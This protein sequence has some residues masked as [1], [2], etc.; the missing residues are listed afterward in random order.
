[1]KLLKKVE[2]VVAASLQDLKQET[3]ESKD[4]GEMSFVVFS[5]C[6]IIYFCALED[7]Q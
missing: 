2:K 4:C 1:M 5:I 3:N 7:E 6:F